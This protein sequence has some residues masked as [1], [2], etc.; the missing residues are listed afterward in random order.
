MKFIQNLKTGSCDL[1]F[2]KEEIKTLNKNKK[3]HFTPES[4]KHFGNCLMKMVAHWNLSF[5]EDLKNKLT[6][7]DSSI[8]RVTSSSPNQQLPRPSL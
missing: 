1:I 7:D 5:Q 2:S 8:G 4:L 3:L 6:D